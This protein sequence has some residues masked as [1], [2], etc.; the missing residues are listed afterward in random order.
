MKVEV[1][2]PNKWHGPTSR[3]GTILASLSELEKHFGPNTFIGSDDD[4]VSHEYAIKVGNKIVCIWA[5]KYN[6]IE[7]GPDIRTSWSIG[8]VSKG[9]INDFKKEI[10]E[11]N[12]FHG[13]ELS[14]IEEKYGYGV[15]G[16]VKYLNNNKK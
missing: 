4:K 6:P 5:Y 14:K 15:N 2:D 1:L 12:I 9:A 16:L 3:N 7:Y 11:L 13:P 10:P 8:E